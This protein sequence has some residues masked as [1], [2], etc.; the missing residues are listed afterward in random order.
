MQAPS[1]PAE[2]LNYNQIA[3]HLIEAITSEHFAVGDLLPTE[4]ALCEHYGTSR[5]T[6]RAALAELEQAGLV[7]RKKNVG[8]RVIASRPRSRFRPTLAS[9]DDL[10]QFGTEHLRQVRNVAEIEA[11]PALAGELGCEAGSRWLRISSLR[12]VGDAEAPPIGWTDVYIDPAYREVVEQARRSPNV[13]ISTLIEESHGRRIAEIHQ[14]V[15]ASTLADPKIATALGVD[16]G[17]AMLG[18]IRRYLDSDGRLFE[19]TVTVHPAER[20]EL[21]MRLRR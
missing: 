20:F 11:S 1:P 4:L 17:T 9:V 19:A 7:L 6:I 16:S 18:I 12:H 3:D 21:S 13:L 15:R 2:R 14:I 8:T 5:H 10:V